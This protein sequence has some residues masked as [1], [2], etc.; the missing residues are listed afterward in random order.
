MAEELRIVL[1][2]AG[3]GAFGP[4]TAIDLM[5][6][7]DLVRQ[8]QVEIVLV[9]INDKT[10][11]ETYRFLERVREANNVDVSIRATTDR[12]DGLPGAHYV[13]VAV[14]V[15]RG[16][17]WRDDQRLAYGYGFRPVTCENG[18]PG[19][20]FH[21]LRQYKQI[22]PIAR[23]IER[24]AP[25]ALLINY[26]NPESRVCLAVTRLTG[27]ETV[28]LC[29]GVS[30][31]LEC[32][33]ELIDRQV[34]RVHMTVGGINHFHW[35]LSLEDTETGADLYPALR[36][37]L[38]EDGAIPPLTELAYRSFGL[39]PFPS[40][41]HIGEYMNF[42]FP[43]IG[44]QHLATA[45]RRTFPAQSA[46]DP[47]KN[48]DDAFTASPEFAAPI[49]RAKELD[50]QIR[51]PAAILPNNGPAIDNLPEDGIVDIPAAIDA[52]GI[53]PEKVGPLPEAIAAMC[54][55]Q[56]SVQNLL[57]EA[58]AKKSKAALLQALLIDPVVDHAANAEAMMND[59]LDRQA[60]YLPE[61]Q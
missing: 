25:G 18:G 19:A 45:I 51:L 3:S 56:L 8:R 17:L 23:D 29:H 39:L 5:C 22:I 60:D 41:G 55:I 50:E 9:D 43:A 13:V 58:Y 61:L 1:I 44:P 26:S 53:H 52:G 54:R 46:V 33:C 10:L 16:P 31:T 2:G 20:A 49:I 21:T 11:N 34:D 42:A 36:E 48:S 40:D 24:L 27:I 35:V 4:K 38:Y 57:L 59:A 28:G 37:A 6:C 12:M 14:E 32:I 15:E 47:G 7:D 30:E